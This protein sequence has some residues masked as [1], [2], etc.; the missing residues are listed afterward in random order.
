MEPL[1]PLCLVLTCQ[2][3]APTT[4]SITFETEGDGA[5]SEE[6][7]ENILV[8]DKNGNVVSLNLPTKFV[9]IANHQV[10]RHS[11]ARP[12]SCNQTD[13]SRLVVRMVFIV[14]HRTRGRPSTRVYHIEE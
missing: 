11:I 1:T 8:K 9:M 7:V 3:F 6:D 2:W 10:R 12:I 13:L 5:F 14:L 4:L